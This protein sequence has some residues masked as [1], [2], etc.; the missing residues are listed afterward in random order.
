[1]ETITEERVEDSK[2]PNVNNNVMKQVPA[3]SGAVKV[4][5]KQ[6]TSEFRKDALDTH[7]KLRAKHRAGKL[8]LNSELCT[9]AQKWAEH[10]STISTLQHSSGNHKGQPLGE[11][12]ASKWGSNGAD[13]TGE[14]A[15]Q[16]WYSEESAYDYSGKSNA[17][18]SG[19]FTQVVW[20]GSE[21]LGI[22]KAAD[23]KGRVY[24][25]ANYSPAGNYIGNFAANVSRP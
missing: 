21:E 16:Q 8:K 7:N 10:L 15:V 9:I 25:V 17:G 6:S 19:H 23:S 5:P 12:I 4:K 24:V 11:N 14:E 13:Y 22:G 20:K 2:S 3:S 1:V 18:A